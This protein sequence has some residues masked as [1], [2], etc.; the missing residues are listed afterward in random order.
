[1]PNIELKIRLLVELFTHLS[2]RDQDAVISVIV[3]IL[4][5]K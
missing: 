5:E 4:S 1:M 2:D 3:S